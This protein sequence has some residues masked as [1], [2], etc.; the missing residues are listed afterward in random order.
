MIV[1]NAIRGTI[2]TNTTVTGAIYPRGE[3]G[4]KGQ[5]GY[6]PVKGVDY[7]TEAEKAEM[8]SAVL[9]DLP[10]YNGEVVTE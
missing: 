8:V 1:G 7:F 5:D 9:A 10:I 6:T 2:Q 3:K 4:E